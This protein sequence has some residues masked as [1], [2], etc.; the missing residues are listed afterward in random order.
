MKITVYIPQNEDGD[1]KLTLNLENSV[2]LNG[3]ESIFVKKVSVFWNYNN[4][5]TGVND[6]ITVAGVSSPVKIPQGYYTYD[7]L[8][9]YISANTNSKIA[10]FKSV[11][12]GKCSIVTPSDGKNVNLG[13]LGTLLGFEVGSE[14]VAGTPLYG[15]EV[16]I[17]RGLKYIDVKCNMVNKSHNIGTNGRVSDSLVSLPICE[18]TLKGSAT[19][20]RDVES[21]VRV[22]GG[23]YNQ[24]SFSVKG[25]N[26]SKRVGA[27]L[28]EMYLS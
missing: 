12:T 5:L 16:D 4:I 28:L 22:N 27:V 21:S 17:N 19:R 18:G 8:T 9:N 3:K 23:A 7:G 24:I 25:S 10:F 6:E 2:T 13:E 26:G 14:A 11:E 15:G 1:T 20:Y